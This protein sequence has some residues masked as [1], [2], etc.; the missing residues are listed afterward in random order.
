[1]K[2]RF[3]NAQSFK[4]F[5]DGVESLRD[6]WHQTYERAKIPVEIL[7]MAGALEGSWHL[8]VLAEDWCG[9]GVGSLPFVARLVE[10]SPNL[11]MRLLSRDE[12]PDLMDRYLTLGTRSIPVII[13][14]DESFEEVGS[15]GPRPEPLQEL[16]LREIKPLP[17]PE[18]FPKLRAWY[19]RDRGRTLLTELLSRI[20]APV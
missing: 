11:E 16:F 2:E 8:L 18:R 19:A 6:L 9:D 4:D 5:L 15:W 13:I 20:P 7:E 14:L 17:Q 12:N 10:A 3:E 1:M